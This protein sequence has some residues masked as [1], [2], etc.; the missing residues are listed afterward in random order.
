M[1]VLSATCPGVRPLASRAIRNVFPN[2]IIELVK[3]FHEQGIS[4]EE[5]SKRID[6]YL[7][8]KARRFHIPKVA[9]FE[10]TPLCNL[11]C[12]MCYVHLTKSQ[13][14][15]TELLS[16]DQWKSI[17]DQS[18]QAGMR[19]ASLTGG[20]C[21]TY[22]GF[23]DLYLYLL[24]KRVRTAVLTNGILLDR[25]RIEFFKRHRPEIIVVSVYG[26]SEDCY[27]AVTGHRVFDIVYNN[28]QMLKS[29]GISVKISVTPNQYMLKHI[30][31]L[32]EKLELLGIPYNINKMLINP[33]E[34]TGRKVEDLT[35]EQY[36]EVH[37]IRSLLRNRK[38][39]PISP[40]ELP[41]IKNQKGTLGLRCGA[42]RSAFS[43]KYDG[44]ICACFGL[45]MDPI[46]PLEIGFE[47]AWKIVNMFAE[48]YPYPSECNG[49][50]YY[51]LCRPCP[52]MHQDAPVLGHCDPSVCEKTK[53]YICA[54]LLPL[55]PQ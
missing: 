25:K 50:V 46:Y 19:M 1:C 29:E 3:S 37:T 7:E 48:N 35:A 15:P 14:N 17:I 52:I 13:F 32:F 31:E 24:S 18:Y 28:L 42:G 20:E 8:E 38:P 23:E 5:Y 41:D 55:P 26:G 51:D 10:L 2:S 30:K 47:E 4:E 44:S 43:I 9:H 36:I 49:C 12:K 34:N 54:G 39:A 33:R 11:D 22:P 21:L 53:A 40:T 16:I 45:Q 6:A 27:E